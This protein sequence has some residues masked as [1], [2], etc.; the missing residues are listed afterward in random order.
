MMTHDIRLKVT[1]HHSGV[2]GYL[3]GRPKNDGTRYRWTFHST[4]EM[5]LALSNIASEKAAELRF[6]LE[7]ARDG[8]E[9]ADAVR[10]LAGFAKTVEVLP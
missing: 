4:S 1:T 2:V 8:G 6:A 10:R 7:D 9:A 5:P 3:V